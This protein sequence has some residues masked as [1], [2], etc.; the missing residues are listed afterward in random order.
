MSDFKPALVAGSGLQASRSARVTAEAALVGC[1]NSG[2]AQRTTN[3][4]KQRD[5]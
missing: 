3:A 4:L 1:S 5:L 2:G